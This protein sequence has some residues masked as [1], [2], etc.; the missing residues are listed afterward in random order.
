MPKAG[1][2]S[3]RLFLEGI[4]VPVI[5]AQLNI[6]PSKPVTASIQI[7]PTD[8]A[9][10]FKPRTLV[11]LFFLESLMDTSESGIGAAGFEYLWQLNQHPQRPTDSTFVVG[12]DH[13]KVLYIGEVVGQTY[14]KTPYNRSLIL[15]CM[16]LSSYWDNCFQWFADYSV[17]GSAFTDKAHIFVG[18]GEGLFDNITGGHT[19]VI[20]RI[21]QSRPQTPGYE[22][23]RGLQGG[24]I[25]LLETVG[26]L[27]PGHRGSSV[28][29]EGLAG[30]NDFF[31]VAEMRY[32]LTSM[33][34]AVREDR[35]SQQIYAGKAFRTWLKNGMS[36]IGNLVSYRNL[37]QQVGRWIFHDIYPN[38]AAYY[39]QGGVT[40]A[41][42][43]RS[44]VRDKKVR[45]RLKQA[46]LH[47]RLALK[48][49]AEGDTAAKAGDVAGAELA[50]G[51]SQNSRGSAL[52]ELKAAMSLANSGLTS[53]KANARITQMVSDLQDQQ[54]TLTRLEG[55]IDNL[56]KNKVISVDQQEGEHL[57]NQLL[58]P[59]TFF[60]APPRCNVIFPD[61]YTQFN[62]SRNFLREVTR[63][64]V[65]GGL[66]VIGTRRLAKLLGRHYFAPPIKDVRGKSLHRTLAYGARVLLPHEVH[67]GII[68]KFEWIPQGHR[69]AARAA[70]GVSSNERVEKS[71]AIP[72]VQR[73]SNFQYFIHRWSS[74]TMSV[75]MKFNPYLV[76]GFPGVVFDR[77]APSPA[78]REVIETILER[79]ITPTQYI[80]KVASIM[81]SVSQQ[82]GLTTA[83]MTHCRTHRGID[84]EFLGIL[85]IGSNEWF[86]NVDSIQTVSVDIEKFV[87][88]VN[89]LSE[90]RTRVRQLLSALSKALIRF[91]RTDR[92]FMTRQELK[93]R[94]WSERDIDKN[95]KSVS[96]QYKDVSARV[97]DA[98]Y[99]EVSLDDH[100]VGAAPEFEVKDSLKG[101]IVPGAGVIKSVLLS[102]GRIK[103]KAGDLPKLGITASKFT[104]FFST[105]AAVIETTDG[106][107]EFW[108]P[109]SV[110]IE[111][112]YDKSQGTKGLPT[113]LAFERALMPGWYSKTWA[114]EQVS[115]KVYGWLLGA[116]A[117][118]DDVSLGIAARESLEKTRLASEVGLELESSLLDLSDDAKILTVEQAIDALSIYYMM[119]QE[120]RADIHDFIQTYTSRPIASLP[121]IM[122]SQDFE[123]DGSG[124]TVAGT[125]GFHSRAFGDYNVGAK[126]KEGQEPEAGA[127]AF[128]GLLGPDGFPKQRRINMGTSTQNAGAI[129]PAFDP[130]GPSRQRVRAYA[131]ELRVSRGLKGS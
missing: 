66:G 53:K 127:N 23:T 63:L 15:Q 74:R 77:A 126:L 45:A 88:D 131:S 28:S 107:R 50:L 65:R 21:L 17:H 26:G 29:R 80:G 87:T 40:K 75:N 128:R 5:S 73:L 68:P 92:A 46:R 51:L 120:A 22:T 124:A 71:K 31:S 10:T 115:E 34:G 32:G 47:L 110:T 100:D 122:G 101:E 20:S 13:Y 56:I 7:V 25:S 38:P 60:I 3:L 64:S 18:A 125:E 61:Q 54:Q 57:F 106:K 58:L 35:T 59:E 24:M 97:W 33:I 113:R 95:A 2:L 123:I 112:G 36:S 1:P 119:L 82:G 114:P 44:V 19:W 41:N 102:P 109:S 111:Y 78:A 81:H 79:D 8:A 37:V 6:T 130:R 72:Y 129:P 48:R 14:A 55:E 49:E 62:Y 93:D 70:A 103:L 116:G 43:T 42:V 52:T 86:K 118:T 89:Y 105:G 27:R 117:I 69:W 11:H 90:N 85:D 39:S 30:V 104:D 84:D 108:F 99:Y 9:L 83:S 12:D 76:L 96:N 94:G 4:E 91:D 121:D 16:D 98:D 67:S